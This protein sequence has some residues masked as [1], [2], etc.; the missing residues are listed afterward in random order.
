M[1]DSTLNRNIKEYSL[2]VGSEVDRVVITAFPNE[3]DAFVQVLKSAADGAITIVEGASDLIIKCDAVDGSTSNTI[4]H[5]FRPTANDATL[6]EIQITI[7]GFY[8]LIPDFHRLE[9]RYILKV[10]VHIQSAAVSVLATNE[11]SKVDR[12]GFDDKGKISLVSS[13]ETKVSFVVTSADGSKNQIYEVV[14]RKG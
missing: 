5:V 11:T 9:T 4:I 8:T 13:A 3:G 10:P 7:D 1:D 2:T 6:K 14:V 12:N